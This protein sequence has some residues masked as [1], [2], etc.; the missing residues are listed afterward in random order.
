MVSDPI[1]DSMFVPLIK[2]KE[3]KSSAIKGIFCN[4]NKSS[5][6]NIVCLIVFTC[7]VKQI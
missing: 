3:V 4:W 2:L 5:E 6:N 7:L 1:P